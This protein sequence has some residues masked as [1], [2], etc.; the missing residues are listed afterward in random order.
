MRFVVVC[1]RRQGVHTAE[2]RAQKGGCAVP[3][4]GAEKGT[5][6]LAPAHFQ[7]EHTLVD[8]GTGSPQHSKSTVQDLNAVLSYHAR[9]CAT[10]TPQSEMTHLEIRRLHREVH[11]LLQAHHTAHK[12]KERDHCFELSQGQI[13]CLKRG[14]RRSAIPLNYE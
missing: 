11:S 4:A 12:E 8:A 1:G 10:H 6:V 13:G 14:V 2:T 9:T 5:A 7:R 3:R